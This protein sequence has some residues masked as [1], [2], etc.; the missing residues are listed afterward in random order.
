MV[1]FKIDSLSCHRPTVQPT[2]LPGIKDRLTIF[3]DT[4]TTIVPRADSTRTP[5]AQMSHLT[6]LSFFGHPY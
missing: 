3:T 4:G 2:Y 6:V 5:P 1:P